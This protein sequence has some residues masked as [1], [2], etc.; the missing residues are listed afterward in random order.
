MTRVASISFWARVSFV[1]ARMAAAKSMF[2]S[3][4]LWE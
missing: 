2:M 1:A 4:F 3:W